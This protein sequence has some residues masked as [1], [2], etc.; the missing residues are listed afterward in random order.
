ML[1]VET[2]QGLNYNISM[3]KRGPKRTV[4]E[5]VRIGEYGDTSWHIEL[6]CGHS[7]KSVR[8]PS[9]GETRLCCKTCAEPASAVPAIIVDDDSM[10]VFDDLMSEIKVRAAI[11]SKVGVPIDQVDIVGGTATVFLDARQVSRLL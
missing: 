1:I 4:T 11:A 3:S 2:G 6:E 8:K 5:A 7:I 10:P 9:V